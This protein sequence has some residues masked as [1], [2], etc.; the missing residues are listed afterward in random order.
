M[1]S[2]WVI[3]EVRRARK[4]EREQNRR[5]LF[6]MSLVDFDAIRDWTCLDTDTGEDIAEEVR[7]YHIPDFSDW[8][9]HDSFEKGFERLLSD[10]RAEEKRQ[11]QQ[12]S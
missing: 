11:A 12:R 6:P 4:T 7:S 5:K 1:K 9:D 10:L 3:R 2:N 8:K